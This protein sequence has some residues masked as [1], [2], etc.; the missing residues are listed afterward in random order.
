M[1]KHPN[2]ILIMTDNQ[3]ADVVGCYGNQEVYTP[4]LDR[5][6]AS[7]ARFE[8]AYCP[9]AMCSPSRASVWTGRLPCQHGVHTWLDDRLADSWPED[10][11]AVDEFDTLPEI[12]K[13]H[14]YAT[15]MIG[16]YHLGKLNKPQNGIDHWITMARGHTLDFY[17]NLMRVNDDTFIHEGHSVDFFS[18]KAVAYIEERADTP[19]DPFLLMLPYNG[20]YGHWPSIKGPAKNEF[21][22]RYLKT[23]MHSIPREGV[24]KETIA[25]YELNRSYHSNKAGGPDFSALIQ[26]PNEL[27]SLRNYF[28]QVSV[29]DKGVGNVFDALE[30]TGL[31]NDTIV[32]FT[33]D[34]G[35][36]LGHHGFWGHGQATWP[37]NAYRVAYH[38]PLLFWGPGHISTPQI[39]PPHV[40]SMDLYATLLGFLGLSGNIDDAHIPSRDFS[41]LLRGED[42]PWDNEV[43]IEQEETRAYRT[44][45]WSYVKRFHGSQHYPLHDELYDTRKD[46]DER[47]N[48][49]GS[50]DHRDIETAFSNK[51]D[52]FFTKYADP[53]FNTWTGGTVKSN[54]SRPWLWKDAWGEDWTPSS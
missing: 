11:N 13:R 1:A 31:T 8:N 17:G 2:I 9:N 41:H 32:I 24:S 39:A 48:L 4:H 25:C 51:L 49:S 22:E 23:P 33:A 27:T 53:K 37:A 46:P 43:F 28:S 35:F 40:S 3:P 42:G 5:M 34:H 10:W 30:R 29:I 20:P 52:A 44:A 12:L 45:G 21:W 19:E 50:A 36:S 6:A 16:K 54:T 47:T 38:I 14:G 26:I 15:A 18:E 7:G